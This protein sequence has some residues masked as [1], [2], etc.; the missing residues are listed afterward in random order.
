[1]LLH[2]ELV[3]FSAFISHGIAPFGLTP[4]VPA[5]L[6]LQPTAASG[7]SGSALLQTL[8]FLYIACYQG[9][10]L[11]QAEPLRLCRGMQS[12]AVCGKK[13]CKKNSLKGRPRKQPPAWCEQ[14]C[15]LAAALRAGLAA[16]SA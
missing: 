5:L 8:L 1:L 2:F 4:E 14:H 3:F 13:H 6:L 12:P 10:W 9:F 15:W 11:Q 7:L 16:C